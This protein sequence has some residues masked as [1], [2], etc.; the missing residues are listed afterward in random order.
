MTNQQPIVGRDVPI[1][2]QRPQQMLIAPSFAVMPMHVLDDNTIGVINQGEA[3][4]RE[5]MMDG[6]QLLSAIQG[7]VR[8][9]RRAALT[10][11]LT[12]VPVESEP[13][14]SVPSS[15]YEAEALDAS[16]G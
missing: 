13:A 3:I 8:F 7:I 1:L 10:E 15:E 2:G 9:E 6:E 4:P 14:A 16:N 12:G 5:W 11:M